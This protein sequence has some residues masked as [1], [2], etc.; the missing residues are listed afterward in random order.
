MSIHSHS[1][2]NPPPIRVWY[3]IYLM[4]QVLYGTWPKCLQAGRMKTTYQHSSNTTAPHVTSLTNKLGQSSG[5]PMS[6]PCQSDDICVSKSGTSILYRQS[7]RFN[8]GKF[9]KPISKPKHNSNPMSIQCQSYANRMT[10]TNSNLGTFL[11]Y[12][13]PS[14]LVECGGRTHCQYIANPLPIHCQS[15]FDTPYT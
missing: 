5:N 15:V 8:E 9:L 4:E 11:L 2:A 3:P 1:T 6:I 7:P 10:I 12:A 13:L 14:S